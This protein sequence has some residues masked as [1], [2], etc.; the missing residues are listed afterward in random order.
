MQQSGERSKTGRLGIR[1]MCPSGAT[2]LP[3]DC[4]F[5]E[6]A[7]KMSNSTCWSR[8]KRTSSSS[9]WKLTCSRHG[10]AGKIAEMALNNNHSLTHSL[11]HSYTLGFGVII[12]FCVSFGIL[13]TCGYTCLTSYFKFQRRVL[14]QQN[15]FNPTTCCYR[16]VCNKPGQ[17]AAIYIYIYIVFVTNRDSERPY[18]YIYIY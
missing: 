18:I 9:H 7:L 16:S 11:T 13:L 2:Y 12:Q 3:A 10:I 5:S 15:Y 17:W 14:G 8:T 4:C 1:I 6:L